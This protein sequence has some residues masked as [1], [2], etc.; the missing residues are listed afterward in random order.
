[1]NRIDA[2]RCQWAINYISGMLNAGRIR[3]YTIP[4]G[5]SVADTH[6]S[7]AW[8]SD[9]RP[10]WQAE[11]HLDRDYAEANNTELARTLAHEGYHGFFNDSTQAI[12]IAQESFCVP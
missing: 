1:M 8:N 7:K 5:T 6:N 10:D 2:D 9:G 4:T 11:I 3:Y 12:A